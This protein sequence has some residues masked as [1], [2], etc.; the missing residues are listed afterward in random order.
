MDAAKRLAALFGRRVVTFRNADNPRVNGITNARHRDLIF[1]NADSTRPYWAVAGHELWHHLVL[2]QPE[3]ANQ[4][5]EAVRPEL[6]NFDQYRKKF[7]GDPHYKSEDIPHELMGDFLGDSVGDASFWTKLGQENPKVLR[8]FAIAVNEWLTKVSAAI[9]RHGFGS[10]SYFKDIDRA[11]SVLADAIGKFGAGDKSGLG[12]YEIHDPNQN[13]YSKLRD[14]H[15]SRHGGNPKYPISD[16]K[17]LAEF[18]EG[19]P[20]SKLSGQEFDKTAEP[21]DKR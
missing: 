21:L 17:K 12:P 4:V 20:V 18:F 3:L 10:D 6:K 15:L 13:F 5:W 8:R 11:Q 14:D 7:R 9:K 1:L 16:A 19:E 2:E